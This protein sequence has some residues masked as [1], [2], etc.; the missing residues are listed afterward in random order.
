MKRVLI[1]GEP[2]A[3]LGGIQTFTS[4]LVK[5]FKNSEE[6]K[7]EIL[8]QGPISD[9]YNSMSPFILGPNFMKRQLHRVPFIKA[10]A[11]K[12]FLKSKNYNYDYILLNYPKDINGLDKFKN[13]IVLVQHQ[14]IAS[15]VKRF[16][17]FNNNKKLIQKVKKRVD[18]IVTLSPQEK[19]E[20]EKIFNNVIVV[21]H[22]SE[23]KV[24]EKKSYNKNI[25]MPARLI[26][27]HKRF[28]IAI[29]LL[30]KI[31]EYELHIYGDGKDKQNIKKMIGDSKNIHLHK[32]TNNL[33]EELSKFSFLLI[34][35]DYEGYPL[36]TIES[37]K[38][39]L[40]PVIRNTYLSAEDIVLDNT[41]LLKNNITPDEFK[42][43]LDNT[44]DNIKVYKEKLKYKKEIYDWETIKDKWSHLFV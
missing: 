34:T 37:I 2:I 44:L 31:P 21:R 14:T 39:G 19:K 40:I 27:K 5:M 18:V 1:I 7:I 17:Y 6:I 22:T 3:S 33:E 42:E 30:K 9:E 35:S 15:W 32:R 10:K 12:K 36:A 23:M 38:K 25:I 16:I 8:A 4:N 13:K 29:N 26:N 24:E 41:F 43:K 28:D 20:L 11:I